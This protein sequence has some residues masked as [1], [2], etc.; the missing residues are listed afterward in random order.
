MTLTPLISSSVQFHTN[1]KII[2]WRL[3][4]F[5]CSKE[6]QTTVQYDIIIHC[7][8]TNGLVQKSTFPITDLI[9]LALDE[10]LGQRL[11]DQQLHLL[12]WQRRFLGADTWN[13][14]I[15]YCLEDNYRLSIWQYNSST[16]PI[17]ELISYYFCMCLM[18][19]GQL[20]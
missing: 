13:K 14:R 10:P 20:K 12:N 17:C 5:M 19:N 16:T 18:H 3:V 15:V 6:D 1:W 2:N 8:P 11:H 7:N 4:T 9:D